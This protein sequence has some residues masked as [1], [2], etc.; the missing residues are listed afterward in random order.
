MKEHNFQVKNKNPKLKNTF[1]N[2]IYTVNKVK[3]L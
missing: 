2:P 1:F 3:N